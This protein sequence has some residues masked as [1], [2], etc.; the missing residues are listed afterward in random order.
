[1]TGRTDVADLTNYEQVSIYR[2]DAATQE[3]LLSVGR[4][5]V[6]NWSTREGWPIG[7]IMSYL[8]KNG[9]VWLTAGAHRHRIEAVVKRPKVSVVI[10]STG[11]EMGPGKTVTIKGRCKVHEDAATKRWFYPEFSRHLYADANRASAFETMLD[12]PLRVILEVIPEKYI[13]Y[14]GAKMFAHTAG[15]ISDADLAPPLSSDTLRLR[16]EIERRGL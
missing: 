2:L 5:C 13:T 15:K 10:T 1:M 16:R 14:D 11:T 12:S 4:E 7:V 8:W 3:Q 6:F 9:R